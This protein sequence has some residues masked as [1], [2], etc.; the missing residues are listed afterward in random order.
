MLAALSAGIVL[1]ACGPFSDFPFRNRWLGA[2]LGLDPGRL[3]TCQDTV[4]P[5]HHW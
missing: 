1:A 5:E 4:Y 2:S 3:D